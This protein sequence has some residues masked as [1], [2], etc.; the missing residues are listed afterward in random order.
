MIRPKI[1]MKKPKK[2]KRKGSDVYGPCFGPTPPLSDA[3]I[4]MFENEN[5]D[6]AHDRRDIIDPESFG[7]SDFL[8]PSEW[9]PIATPEQEQ[10][11]KDLYEQAEVKDKPGG[12]WTVGS[13]LADGFDMKSPWIQTYSGRR[14]N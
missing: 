6:W 11:L 13:G 2:N 3:Q 5:K 10:A 14:F 4:K 8:D 1:D 7:G 12:V 9:G